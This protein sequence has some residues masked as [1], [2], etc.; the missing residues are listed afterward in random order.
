MRA[1]LLSAGLG[2]RLRPLTN[3]VPKCLVPI[4]GRPLLDIWLE[5][6]TLS[7]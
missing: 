2:T 1:I 7:G 6:L 5:K 4:N 3:E